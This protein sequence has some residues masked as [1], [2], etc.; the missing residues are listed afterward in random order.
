MKSLVSPFIFMLAII[1]VNGQTTLQY[2]FEVDDTFS[3]KQTAEQVITQE[4]EGASHEITN[5]ID[6][7]LGFKVIAS[8][9]DSYELEL[10]FKDLNLKMT[11]SIQGDLMNVKASVIEEDNVQSK[12][13]NSLL[14]TPVTLTLSK[15][16]KIL[17]VQGGDSLVTRM[18][19]ASGLEDDFSLN[20]MKKSLEK[21]FGSKA[22][23]ESYEQM[24][25]IYSDNA[26]RI[27]DTWKNNYTG[28]LAVENNWKLEELN[29]TIAKISGDANIIMSV[30]EPSSTMNLTGK[31]ITQIITNATSGLIQNMINEE[32]SK[33]SKKKSYYKTKKQIDEAKIRRIR[34]SDKYKREM[35][36]QKLQKE[37]ELKK[38][39]IRKEQ[40]R[41]LFN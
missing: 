12:V 18:V 39:N 29:E 28:K 17:S 14:N 9:E 13:F 22:L 36:E 7:I 35:M 20:M 32:K 23:S 5:N 27:G 31:Q 11:S 40:E 34:A 30:S 8:K 10:E 37:L 3:F 33:K 21:E 15:N 16:G 41:E 24:T 2:N 4:F 26:I 1:N 6:G 38:E 25:Y 19:N